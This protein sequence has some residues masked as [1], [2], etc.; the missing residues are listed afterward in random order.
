FFQIVDAMKNWMIER[1][2]NR[3]AL[4]KDL[5]HCF[6]QRVPFEFAPEIVNHQKS[7][8]EQITTQGRDFIGSQNDPSRF[9]QVNEGILK[10]FGIRQPKDFS[11]WIDLQRRQ[12]L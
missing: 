8:V 12:L 6:I 2:F 7:A 3:F 10:Q 1:Q 9:N 4:R 11:V 5:F